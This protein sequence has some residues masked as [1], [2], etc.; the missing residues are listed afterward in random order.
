MAE[1]NPGRKVLR[2]A[3]AGAAMVAVA[4]FAQTGQGGAVSRAD[5]SPDAA[6]H[7]VMM[8]VHM[9]E[10]E[11]AQL[12]LAA[13]TDPAV[14]DFATRLHHDHM[15]AL[16]RQQTALAG[17]NVDWDFAQAG[18][19]WRGM[20]MGGAAPI[21][22][23]QGATA[24]V[25]PDRPSSG[26]TRTGIVSEPVLNEAQAGNP[27]AGRP[28]VNNA[29]TP[30]QEAEH[31]ARA[32]QG[33]GAPQGMQHQGMAQGVSL[34]MDRAALMHPL[35]ERLLA[36]RFAQPI[37]ASHQDAMMRLSSLSGRA[38]DLAYLDRQV[39]AHDYALRTLDNLLP[40][41]RQYGSAETAQMLETMRGSVSNHL[42]MARELRGR[43]GR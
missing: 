26:P 8:S 23:T 16:E 19:G 18:A 43:M 9:G 3:L 13:A 39:A 17:M 6:A 32:G 7:A 4:A 34:R 38:F 35:A 37:V 14:R 29:R 28:D 11:E 41:V 36:N 22:G 15:A 24:G 12:A 1:L 21:S 27:P 30:E 10:I 20:G 33:A 42:A 40:H 2:A 25:R 5:D 31:Q